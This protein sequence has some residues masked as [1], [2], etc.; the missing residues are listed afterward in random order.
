MILFWISVFVLWCVLSRWARKGVQDFFEADLTLHSTEGLYLR[1]WILFRTVPR[2]LAK[3][4][5][6]WLRRLVDHRVF[7]HIMSGPDPDRALH[8]H[9]WRAFAVV[10]WG[11]YTQ[12]RKGRDSGYRKRVER[13]RW[14]NALRWDDYHKIVSVIPGTITLMVGGP[15]EREWSFLVDG[16]DIVWTEYLGVPAGTELDD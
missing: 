2:V 1:R 6:M 5:P 4:L 16:K 10:L 15:R 9:P 14:F 7:L 3:R 8:N 11:G 12:H 13:I